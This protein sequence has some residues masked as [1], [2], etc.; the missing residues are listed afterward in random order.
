M[1][2][3]SLVTN[4]HLRIIKYWLTIISSNK[5]RFI[6]NTYNMMLNDIELYPNKT[7]W[8]KLVKNLL[9]SLGFA[10]AWLYQSVGNTDLFLLEVRQCLN[11]NFI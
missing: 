8:A 5:H 3:K 6:K 11:D 1:D 9:K 10:D 7:N 4:R 2:R